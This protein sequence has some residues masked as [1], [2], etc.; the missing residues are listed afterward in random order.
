MNIKYC[1]PVLTNG[2]QNDFKIIPSW[3]WVEFEAF[4]SQWNKQG[5]HDAQKI[6]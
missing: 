6:V 3:I 2:P 1:Y 5:S 4:E